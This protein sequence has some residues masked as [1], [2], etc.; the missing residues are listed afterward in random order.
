MFAEDGDT[1]I[2]RGAR[3]RGGFSDIGFDA[4]RATLLQARRHAQGEV[5]VGR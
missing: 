4:C 5:A 3:E 2:L 1:I